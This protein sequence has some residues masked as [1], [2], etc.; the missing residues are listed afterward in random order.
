MAESS[1]QPRWR[2][3]LATPVLQR[4]LL[5]LLATDLRWL[6]A[7]L[8]FLTIVLVVSLS[9]IR[10]W[11]STPPGFRPVLRIKPIDLLQSRLAA[12]EA[13][14]LSARGNAIE[15]LMAWQRA[16][17]N[18]PGNLFILREYL[19]RY[20]ETTGHVKASI[21]SQAVNQA[22][23]LLRLTRTNIADMDLV[24][25]LFAR[26]ERWNETYSML[27]DVKDRT[28]YQESVYLRALMQ[29][30]QVEEFAKRWSEM[31]PSLR[32]NP[33]LRLYR[34]AYDAGWG[35]PG[36]SADGWKALEGALATR[37]LRLPAAQL[38][39]KLFAHLSDLSRYEEQLAEI[40][41]T[42]EDRLADHLDH[43]RLLAKVGRVAEA[44]RLTIEKAAAAN[45]PWDVLD[46]AKVLID[47]NEKEEATRLMG[48][49]LV[50]FG[51]SA[52]SWS[53]GLWMLYGTTLSQLH[54]WDD[55]LAAADQL[56]AE[57]AAH[58]ELAGYAAYLEGRALAAMSRFA[59]SRA[60]F[61]RA[62]LKPPPLPA[63]AMGMAAS[64]TQLGHP[65]LAL[66]ILL[67]LESECRDDPAYWQLLA[68][69]A[70]GE[71][72]NPTLL[73][74]ATLEALR[75]DPE[76][77]ALLN[78]HAAALLVNHTAPGY[79]CSITFQLVQ[80]HPDHAGF[81]L[82]HALALTR[83]RRIDEADALLA[84]IDPRNLE[85]GDR[86][87]YIRVALESA[88][89]ARDRARVDQFLPALDRTL[90]F[91]GELERIEEQIAA[92]PTR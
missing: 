15:S 81:R 40:Q 63:M 6:A 33:E 70:Y 55:L 32:E 88:L 49:A 71:R 82:N 3:L 56:R 7:I 26:T 44:R 85:R 37:D 48:R 41:S 12:K 91:P 18:D 21:T 24:A 90:L 65:D 54:R 77:A 13:R 36:V 83:N 52:A 25:G 42:F 10:F 47:L 5:H 51:N 27:K 59:A 14:D 23:W 74:R 53:V 68:D 4:P 67:R 92:L 87:T 39:L 75:L 58:S 89:I 1:P 34:A 43:Y 57:P 20:M 2:E 64:I 76:N 46:T 22:A 61:E 9:F 73:L 72:T 8:V 45:T 50:R 29:T 79:A 69:V 78:N 17:S 30:D 16:I 31:K 38:R 66:Q 11:P 35:A 19:S 86:Q 62:V 84:A 28:D 60:A 80:R